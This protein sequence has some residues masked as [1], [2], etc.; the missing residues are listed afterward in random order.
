MSDPAWVADEAWLHVEPQPDA[1]GPA[2]R[3]AGTGSV[4]PASLPLRVR[5]DQ[6]ASAVAGDRAGE[7]EA[8][9]V[10]HRSLN[11]DRGDYDR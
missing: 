4:S 1:P 10:V 9:R 6:A 5:A 8:K 7:E 2:D 11:H 3:R